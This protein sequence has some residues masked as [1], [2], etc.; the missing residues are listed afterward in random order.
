MLEL[1]GV[2]GEVVVTFWGFVGYPKTGCEAAKELL[3]DHGR[4]NR[5]KKPISEGMQSR[6]TVELQ[7]PRAGENCGTLTVAP[8]SMTESVKGNKWQP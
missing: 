4:R 2:M 6:R 1:H 5:C 7:K 8:L 3:A